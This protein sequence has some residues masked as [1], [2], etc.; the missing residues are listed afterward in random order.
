MG[1]WVGLI[2]LFS[3][4][5]MESKNVGFFCLGIDKIFK[6]EIVEVLNRVWSFRRI[7]R[8]SVIFSNFMGCIFM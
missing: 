4:F 8:K 3:W 1:N 6:I 7:F 5:F 2:I